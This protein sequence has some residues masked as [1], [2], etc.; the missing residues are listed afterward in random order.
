MQQN[1]SI[2]HFRFS[3]SLL[4]RT[5]AKLTPSI[6]TLFFIL[7]L[8][9][10]LHFIMEKE[11]GYFSYRQGGWVQRRNQ[12]TNNS[13]R[14]TYP[15]PSSV[16]SI[17]LYGPFNFSFPPAQSLYQRYTVHERVVV[18][19]VKP[20]FFIIIAHL[21][22]VYLS[23]DTFLLKSI[24]FCV[25]VYKLHIFCCCFCCSIFMVCMSSSLRTFLASLFL[26][27]FCCSKKVMCGS[28][29]FSMCT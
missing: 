13:T 1:N 24:L 29:Y 4:L 14:H 19:Q 9:Y 10:Q 3:F 18:F 28:V 25:S 7:R 2:S 5:P 27:P 11:T 20:C 15:P 16:L 12:T 23:D 6:C 21:W 17:M 22:I 8:H 26:L